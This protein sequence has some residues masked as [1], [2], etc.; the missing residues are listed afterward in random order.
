MDV[1]LEVCLRLFV[2]VALIGLVFYLFYPALVARNSGRL[3]EQKTA[4]IT[5]HKPS[6]QQRPL[7]TLVIPAY[8]EEDRLPKMLEQAYGYLSSKASN[9]DA[10]P[11]AL[12]S[13]AARCDGSSSKDKHCV[14]WIVVSD[15]STD[16][17]SDV[18]R[19]FIE[20]HHSNDGMMIWKLIAFPSNQ[21]KG[22]AVRAGM[23]ASTAEY[24]LMVDADGATAFGPGL[25]ALAS[26]NASIIWGS[27]APETADRSIVRWILTTVFHWCVVIF[28][29]TGE[30]RDTQCGFK[31]L[32]H[33]AAQELFGS[34]HLQ[35]WA[36]DTELLFLASQLEHSMVEVIVPWK[37]VEGS[38]LHTSAL[39][40]VLVSLGKYFE[41]AD[42]GRLT[43]IISKGC[44]ETWFVSDYAILSGCGRSDGSVTRGRSA[45]SSTSTKTCYVCSVL[46]LPS[47]ALP[48]HDERHTKKQHHD[49]IRYTNQRRPYNMNL[50][51]RSYLIPYL[52]FLLLFLLQ[53]WRPLRP[54]D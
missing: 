47:S 24:C 28:V 49:T 42:R 41:D 53:L 5:I 29:G 16:R 38:K 33:A 1:N 4:P 25:E 51:S 20:Q 34:L 50:T 7:L 30:I 3:Q 37:E 21:G 31:L 46:V 17:T 26:H 32:T 44:Y 35:R 45:V 39:N 36:F 19:S 9:A 10:A 27:R 43:F 15:G 54:K 48:V 18:Y 23:L 52:S 2:M 22:A 13:L 11:T 6:K 40:L 12:Q 8:N 14:E